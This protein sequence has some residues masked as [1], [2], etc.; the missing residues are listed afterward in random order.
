MCTERNTKCNDWSNAIIINVVSPG[1]SMLIMI[2]IE[3]VE[4]IEDIVLNPMHPP[5]YLPSH[6]GFSI[7]RLSATL[8]IPSVVMDVKSVTMDDV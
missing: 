7:I 8:S 1:F 2:R 5:K 4:S 6:S 3:K